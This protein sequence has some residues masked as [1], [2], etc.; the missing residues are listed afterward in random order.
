M[1]VLMQ[2]ET[3]IGR[4]VDREVW[5]EAVGG[6]QPECTLGAWSLGEQAEG[7]GKGKSAQCPISLGASWMN[8]ELIW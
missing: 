8:I 4:E 6:Q 3:E 7:R 1:N 5:Q 2:W